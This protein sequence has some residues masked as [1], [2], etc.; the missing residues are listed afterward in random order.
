[1]AGQGVVPI[2]GFYFL[3]EVGSNAKCLTCETQTFEE[4]EGE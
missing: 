3:C 2:F 1:M 4:T